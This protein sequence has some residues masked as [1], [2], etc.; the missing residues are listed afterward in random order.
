MQRD[1][2]CIRCMAVFSSNN[3]FYE[4]KPR[5]NFTEILHFSKIIDRIPRPFPIIYPLF[6]FNNH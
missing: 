1:L 4:K 3:Y 6:R 2:T 5:L